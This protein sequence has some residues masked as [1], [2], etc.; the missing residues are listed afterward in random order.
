MCYY[1]NARIAHIFCYYI[2]QPN[3][4]YIK[5]VSLYII[6]TP[7]CFDISVSLSGNLIFV[8]NLHKIL[9]LKPLKYNFINLLFKVFFKILLN[10]SLM[11]Q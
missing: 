7:A 1:I 2:Y 3:H 4:K 6:Y 8:S 10:I 9:L 5:S 11:M